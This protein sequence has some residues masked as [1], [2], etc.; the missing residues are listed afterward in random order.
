[1]RIS[2]VALVVLATLVASSIFDGCRSGGHEKPHAATLNWTAS[3]GANSYNVYRS[4]VSGG[5]Y[6]KIGSSTE[7]KYVD[8]PLPSGQEFFYVVTAVKGDKESS[9]SK[10]IHVKVP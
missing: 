9:Y 5:P 7:P 3:S 8:T 10:E 4:Q 6:Q 1:M 2:Q